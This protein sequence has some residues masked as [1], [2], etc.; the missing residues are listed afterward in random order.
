[1]IAFLA[2]AAP[3]QLRLLERLVNIDSGTFDKAGVD[4]V[5]S[6]L[7]PCLEELGLAVETVPQADRGDHLAG[8]K[9]GACGR[10]VLLVGH[11]DTVFPPG[12]AAQ[13]PFRIAGGRAYGPGVLDMKAGLT[14]ILFALRA[15][16]ERSPAAWAALGVR[17]VFNSDEETGSDSS[18][19]LIAGEARRAG[20][21]CILEPGRPGG[22]YVSQRK[23]V[24]MFRL[25]AAGKAA[26]A[27]VQPELGANAVVD[28]AHKVVALHALT[29]PATG[30]T[31]NV[32]VIQGGQ[33]GNVVPDHATCE[34]D[35]RI[36][37]ADLAPVL[38]SALQR[39]AGTAHVPG[40]TTAL[41]GGFKHLPM[42][43]NPGTLRLFDLLGRAGAE[44]GVPVRHIGTGGASD[45]NTTAQYTPTLD[46]MGALGNHA[47]SPDEYIE[48]ASLT[49]RTQMLA[50]FLELW[51]LGGTGEAGDDGGQGDVRP[52]GAG[53]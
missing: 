17:V 11:M 18:R 35:V 20:A 46:G 50:R 47:H 27:G 13:R 49:R 3:E 24:G 44:L 48:V 33:R 8:H 16:R 29:D 32:G 21:A 9:P 36:T 34:V 14:M 10:E 7:R 43:A 51:A 45:G 25:T 40:T 1:M 42:V 37:R 31:V 26:H 15:L 23:G 38:E 28:L 12:T 30:V 4:A 53:S 39:M 5:G 52:G 2:Q 6:L 22:E 41:T 19:D